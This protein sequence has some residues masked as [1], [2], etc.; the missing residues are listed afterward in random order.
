MEDLHPSIQALLR[1]LLSSPLSELGLIALD[2]LRSG[3][4]DEKPDVATEGSVEYRD[5]PGRRWE[6]TP[7]D[8]LRQLK[9]VETVISHWLDDE[10]Q[11]A[12][13]IPQLA[14]ELELKAVV[15][16]EQGEG[17]FKGPDSPSNLASPIRVQGL[18]SFGKSFENTIS[19]IR[20]NI[21]QRPV[22]R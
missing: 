6:P 1:G 14:R 22:I 9:L 7:H 12:G 3:P 15:F 8:A 4:V 18:Q 13:E 21:E 2:R 10:L 20:S 19:N 5:I 11:M 16:E 17:F